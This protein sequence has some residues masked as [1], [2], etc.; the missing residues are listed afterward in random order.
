MLSPD[1]KMDVPIDNLVFWTCRLIDRVRT[2]SQLSD[3]ERRVMGEEFYREFQNREDEL[4]QAYLVVIRC[5]ASE[6][7]AYAEQHGIAGMSFEQVK[8]DPFLMVA[9]IGQHIGLFEDIG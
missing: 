5:R 7:I 3:A 1:D 6:I 4:R 9:A 2:N 8:N